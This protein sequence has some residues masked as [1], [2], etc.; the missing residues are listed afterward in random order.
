MKTAGRFFAEPPGHDV[1]ISE[2]VRFLYEFV[3]SFD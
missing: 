3:K 1:K 2:L